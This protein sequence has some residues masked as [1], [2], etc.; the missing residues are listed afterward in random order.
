[1]LVVSIRNY[2]DRR[3]LLIVS[4]GTLMKVD[5]FL[6]IRILRIFS[7]NTV[8]SGRELLI[9]SI[10]HNNCGRKLLIV[11]CEIVMVVAMF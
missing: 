3:K 5:I 1:M 11:H 2:N 10:K 6:E 9:L 4:M 7:L 8:N